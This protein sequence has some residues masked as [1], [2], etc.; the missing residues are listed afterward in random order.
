MIE[1]LVLIGRFRKGRFLIQ[2]TY[3]A[4]NQL[5]KA[6]HDTPIIRDAGIKKEI[7]LFAFSD[8]VEIWAKDAYEKLQTNEP[9]D[10]SS[11]A[12]EVMGKRNRRDSGNELS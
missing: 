7:V 8:R 1:T 6:T 4:S 12:E 10:F 11:L 9:E 3:F 5:V 2:Q